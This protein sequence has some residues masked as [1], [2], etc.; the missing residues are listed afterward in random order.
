MSR[1][2]RCPNCRRPVAH[3]APFCSHCGQIIDQVALGMP[4]AEATP[5]AT[6]AAPSTGKGCRRLVIGGLVASLAAIA[7]AIASLAQM[8]LLVPPPP[9]VVPLA[10]LLSTE[11]PRTTTPAPLP[12]PTPPPT[13]TPLPTATRL[14]TVAPLV[15]DTP[16]VPVPSDILPTIM[17]LVPSADINIAPLEEGLPLEMVID[18]DVTVPNVV[19]G[20]IRVIQGGVLRLNGICDGDVIVEAGGTAYIAGIVSGNVVLRGGTLAEASGIIVGQIVQE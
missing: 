7:I 11:T 17:A 10:V 2:Q 5:T 9:T 6:T 15:V 19:T 16:V 13:A 18:R 12:S 20:N 4:P 1:Q 8:G 3:N 14:P